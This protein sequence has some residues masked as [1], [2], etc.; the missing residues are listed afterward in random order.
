MTRKTKRLL[1]KSGSVFVS[2]ALWRNPVLT[3]ALGIY[4]VIAAACTLKTGIALALMML[5]TMPFV[6]LIFC[7]VGNRI[8]SWIRPGAVVVCSAVFYGP[9]FLLVNYLLPNV[10]PELTLY[11][12][13]MITNSVVLS[14]ANDYAPSHRAIAVVADSLGS[15]A[16]FAGT[17]ILVSAVRGLWMN[18]IFWEPA[19]KATGVA[20]LPFVGLILLAFLAALLQRANHKRALHKTRRRQERGEQV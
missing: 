4:P 17:V 3:A 9:A 14:H 1:R 5:F 19:S 12:P 6:C 13:L 16:G 7:F 20:S 11:A 10:L 15:T 2:A 18:G 8:P